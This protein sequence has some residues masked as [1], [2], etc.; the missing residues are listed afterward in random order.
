MKTKNGLLFFIT[1]L[2]LTAYSCQ[3]KTGSQS[4]KCSVKHLEWTRN[5]VI[6]EVNVRQYTPEGTFSAFQSYLPQLKELGVDVLWFMPIHP[7][8]EK[9]RKG[10]L[11]SYYAVTDYKGVNPEFGTQEDFK[12]LVEK[13][14]ELGFKVII[15][16]VAN[17]TGRDNNW[18]A[19]KPEYFVTDST[20]NPVSPYDWTD[21]AKLNYEN[22]EMRKAMI[23]AMKYWLTDFD[24]D[25][26]RCDVAHEVP[27]DFWN[28]ARVELD[29]VKPIFMLAEAEKAELLNHAFDVDYA[30]EL[31]HIMNEVAKGAKNANDINH[32]LLKNDTLLCP[33][34][35]KM[36]FITNHDENSWNGT[37]YERYGDAVKTFAVLTY[38][39]NGMPLIYTGQ[40]VGLKKRLEFFERDPIS[41]WDKNET[42]T[43]YQRLNEL[44]H[45]QK[46]L[47]AGIDGGKTNRIKTSA[48]DKLF[49]F[50]R[51]NDSDEIIVLLN[52]SGVDVSFSIENKLTETTYTEY[53]SGKES[54]S[55]PESL[56]PWE[57]QILIKT[58]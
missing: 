58:R 40:E 21:V 20:G 24:I 44:K 54:T 15:D 41:S 3:P 34:A 19:S 29:K 53:F 43:F 48:D 11:G 9:N 52:L 23:D 39:L 27:V 49:I 56:K 30:W 10:T 33:D 51:T 6:Y 17:H 26:F 31:M 1:V 55:L 32:Y 35:F 7:I 22:K 28:D 4:E 47:K 46:V 42:F 5:A 25:G 8:S 57:Y 14:H 16:W 12:Q 37:E 45:N 2:I 50:S 36:N 18:I 38:T 13:A